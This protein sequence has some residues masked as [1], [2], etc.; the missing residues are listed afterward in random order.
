[1]GFSSGFSVVLF[2]M[3]KNRPDPADAAAL[4]RETVKTRGQRSVH[5]QSHLGNCGSG[6]TK[7]CHIIEME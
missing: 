6:N 1:M 7:S 4:D 2:Q 3:L 5:R